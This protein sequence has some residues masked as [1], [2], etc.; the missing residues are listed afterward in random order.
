MVISSW[1][2]IRDRHASL[3][4]TH[5]G[6]VFVFTQLLERYSAMNWLLIMDNQE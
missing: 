5:G 4:M 1:I 6:H 3:A 2:Q